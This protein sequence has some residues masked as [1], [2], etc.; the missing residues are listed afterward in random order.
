M[1]YRGVGGRAGCRCRCGGQ[2]KES[3]TAAIPFDPE[4]EIVP[5]AEAA[6][7]ETIIRLTT[8]LMFAESP[9]PNAAITALIGRFV[10]IDAFSQA[11]TNPLLSQHVFN[12]KTFTQEGLDCIAATATLE[13]VLR[14]NVAD[15]A[16]I[17]RG[18][19]TMTQKR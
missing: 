4:L 12:A 11:F 18:S 14:R 3:P 2:K 7:I 6:Q 8:E 19:V 16:N 5:K 15:P 17:A 10:A 13:D 9:R 1:A